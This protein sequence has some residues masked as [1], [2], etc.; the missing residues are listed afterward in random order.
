ME[1]LST[2]PPERETSHVWKH[3]CMQSYFETFSAF[4]RL[5]D[6]QLMQE[7]VERLCAEL[8]AERETSRK[9]ATLHAQLL[10]LCEKALV[11]K[12]AGAR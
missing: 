1:R 12:S 4:H 8:A 7:E 5:T 6:A 11:P 2:C 10:P 9:W 3:L